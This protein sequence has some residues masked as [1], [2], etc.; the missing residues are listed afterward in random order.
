MQ[1]NILL[2]FNI[3]LNIE[4]LLYNIINN[5]AML[6]LQNANIKTKFACDRILAII[7]KILLWSY[8][9][10]LFFFLILRFICTINTKIKT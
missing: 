7:V 8:T 10:Y 3:I 4:E 6:L 2:I 5:I 1:L 9:S